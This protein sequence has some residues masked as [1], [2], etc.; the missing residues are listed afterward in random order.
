MTSG[1]KPRTVTQPGV[2]PSFLADWFPYPQG[3]L[4]SFCK[5]VMQKACKSTQKIDCYIFG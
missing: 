1:I 5:N 3:A 2:K 4:S